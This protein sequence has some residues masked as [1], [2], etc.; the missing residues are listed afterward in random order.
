MPEI[1]PFP[2]EEAERRLA[3]WEETDV[4]CLPQFMWEDALSLLRKAL[5]EI[6]RL[7]GEVNYG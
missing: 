4:D 1:T 2:R 5:V 3:N 7:R 6:D